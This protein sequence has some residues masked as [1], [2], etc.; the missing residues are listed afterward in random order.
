VRGVVA[1]AGALVIVAVSVLDVVVGKPPP[2]RG[3]LCA[4]YGELR[5]SLDVGSLAN[6]V[7]VRAEASTVADLS[8]RYQV[9]A[10][11]QPVRWTGEQIH[12]VLDSRYATARDL[13]VALRPV[14]VECGDGGDF[15]RSPTLI[16]RLAP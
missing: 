9:P 15:Y 1:V 14:A 10:G 5:A 3:T 4:A 13:F 12:S 16:E 2:D 8:E 7:S 11:G 6:Q